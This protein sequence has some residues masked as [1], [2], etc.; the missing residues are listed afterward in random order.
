MVPQGDSAG[1]ARIID[2][3]LGDRDLYEKTSRQA[4][5]SYERIP[6]GVELQRAYAEVIEMTMRDK[7]SAGEEL[8]D[9][10]AAFD[11]LMPQMRVCFK[12]YYDRGWRD[13]V[14]RMPKP[15]CAVGSENHSSA[16]FVGLPSKVFWMVRTYGVWQTFKKVM[17]KI[18]KVV[19]GGR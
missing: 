8:A 19:I 6:A 14:E 4:R 5:A 9:A 12:A 2:R 1:A 18:H 3:L 17:C 7:G 16:H 11:S 10:R 13:A 15:T